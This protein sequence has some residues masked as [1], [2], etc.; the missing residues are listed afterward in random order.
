[1]KDSKII[2]ENINLFHINILESEI[3]D[4]LKH[5][6]LIFDLNVAHSILHNLKDERV[7]IGLV[8]NIKNKNSDV[9]FKALFNI[10][11][12]YKIKDLNH[13]YELEKDDNLVFSGTLISTL[14]GISF[15]TARGIIY[16]RLAATNMKDIILPVVS[17]SKILFAKK[18]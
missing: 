6:K 7:K 13:F 12:H 9:E 1:M 18:S 15:S 5:E 4:S 17:P 8:L 3:T 10:D 16:Q 2:P 14:I 11:F